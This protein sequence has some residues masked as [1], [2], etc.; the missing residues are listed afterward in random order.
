M[1]T[2]L[3]AYY[4][5]QQ[6]GSLRSAKEIVPLI[7]EYIQPKSVV[8]VGCGVGTWLSVF[9]EYGVQDVMGIDNGCTDSDM[10]QIPSNQ[11]MIYDLQKPL[12]IGK[13]YDL[14]VSLEVAE[15]LPVE[16]AKIFID[17]LVRLGSIVL[18]SAAI[19]H[20]GGYLHLNEQWPEFWARYFYN[21]GYEVIDCIR[22]K[23]WRNEK[24]EWWYA[25]NMFI[26]AKRSY[27]EKNPALKEQYENTLTTQLSIVHPKQYLGLAQTMNK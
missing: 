3:Q 7:L 12:D 17:S 13:R 14:V 2:D 11:F 18:F 8:D 1:Q 21:H 16:C 4:Q 23:V 24:V 6:E 20:Q 26:Y 10:L 15:H 9:K 27:L 25:Q 5:Y 19:P 22:Q